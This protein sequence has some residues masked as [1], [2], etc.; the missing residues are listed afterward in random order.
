[1]KDKKYYQPGYISEWA[2]IDF[3]KE[4]DIEQIM[5]GLVQCCDARGVFSPKKPREPP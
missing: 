1:M 3:A 4:R 5:R 2:V